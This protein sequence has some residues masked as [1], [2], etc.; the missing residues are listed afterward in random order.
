MLQPEW[1]GAFCDWLLVE[2]LSWHCAWGPSWQHGL[3]Q[4]QPPLHAQHFC[5]FQLVWKAQ[6]TTPCLQQN[7]PSFGEAGITLPGAEVE[8]GTQVLGSER[9]NLPTNKHAAFSGLCRR[10]ARVER[11]VPESQTGTQHPWKIPGSGLRPGTEEGASHGCRIDLSAV[12][13]VWQTVCSLALRG[14]PGREVIVP[15]PTVPHPL[16]GCTPF[17]PHLPNPL[18]SEPSPRAASRE[19]CAPGLPR[20]PLGPSLISAL[21]P[22]SRSREHFLMALW[23]PSWSLAGD[24]AA[25]PTGRELS[26]AGPCLGPRAP[27]PGSQ[28]AST[29]A[30]TRTKGPRL[31]LLSCPE[32]RSRP[33]QSSEG[34]G[35]RVRAP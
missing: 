7:L 30:G 21:P 11:P 8:V 33:S 18:R 32:A 3:G 1:K 23:L 26:H 17:S 9:G 13:R 14:L 19:V 2:E 28:L 6:V 20:A 15:N 24:T 22:G 35:G 27:P 10:A 31:C 5:C 25:L 4:Q 12:R 34:R 29:N 16:P